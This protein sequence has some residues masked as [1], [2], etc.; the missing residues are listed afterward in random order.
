MNSYNDKQQQVDSN[1]QDIP[2]TKK[3]RMSQPSFEFIDKRPD[4]C[5]Q[6]RLIESIKPP[7][8]PVIPH[9]QPPAI[10]RMIGMEIELNIPF[11]QE[12]ENYTTQNIFPVLNSN[13]RD[14]LTENDR[15]EISSFLWGGCE[16]GTVYGKSDNFDI[17]ADHGGFS[18]AHKNFLEEIT[19]TLVHNTGNKKSM[20]NMEYRTIPFEERK[21]SD[22]GKF[23]MTIKEIQDHANKSRDKATSKQQENLDPPAQH[24]YTGIPTSA[25][26]RLTEK[27]QDA[28]TALLTLIEQNIPYAYYQTTTGLLPS[29]IPDFFNEA[30]RDFHVS[31]RPREQYT[32]T[33]RIAIMAKT[34][35]EKSIWIADNTMMAN[36]W[37]NSSFSEAELKSI[38]GWLTLVAEYMLGYDLEITSLRFDPITQKRRTSTKK[39][40]LPYLSKTPMGETLQA[41]PPVVREHIYANRD[42]W[43]QLFTDMARIKNKANI[44]N[45]IGERDTRIGHGE[46]FGRNTTPLSWIK[47]LLHKYAK[48]N[49][50]LEN[51]STELETRKDSIDNSQTAGMK[52]NLLLKQI[53][54]NT[55]EL[56]D[57][58]IISNNVILQKLGVP[59]SLPSLRGWLSLIS[60]MIYTDRF[61]ASCTYLSQNKVVSENFMTELDKISPSYSD[62]GPTINQIPFRYRPNFKREIDGKPVWKEFMEQ[63]HSLSMESNYSCVLPYFTEKEWDTIKQLVDYANTEKELIDNM[64]DLDEETS[65]ELEPRLSFNEEQAIPLEDRRTANKISYQG[66]SDIHNLTNILTKEWERALERRKRSTYSRTRL[67]QEYNSKLPYIKTWFTEYVPTNNEVKAILQNL[68]Q[69]DINATD[70]E[71]EYKRFKDY[72][73]NLDNYIQYCKQNIFKELRMFFFGIQPPED[74]A[75]NFETFNILYFS[76]FSSEQEVNLFFRLRDSLS[77]HKKIAEAEEALRKLD[78]QR[79][80][81]ETEK[82]AQALRKGGIAPSPVIKSS[83]P[84]ITKP[85]LPQTGLPNIRKL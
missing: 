62:I 48:S 52:D 16:Y 75:P 61:K 65:E 34:H 46:M 51:I 36:K 32:Q 29:E 37:L 83:N 84:V 10:Q 19:G 28:R 49:I 73:T 53:Y 74:I 56:V 18:V 80:Q 3:N 1:R 12:N 50:D 24:M 81:A 35:L 38:K 45:A 8:T 2:S 15:K 7:H 57:R 47:T 66:A 23:D 55:E 85:K 30:I 59:P 20:T 70:A 76:Q 21:P 22:R 33:D 5:K 27:D 44:F 54:T 13:K 79:Q 60:L 58:T 63:F 43:E 26:M 39:N 40:I 25:L 67:T 69:V 31:D 4:A 41:L 6:M 17:S 71:S 68:M 11:Y 82:K 14:I 64:L 42:K 72:V 77:K 9:S 78:L